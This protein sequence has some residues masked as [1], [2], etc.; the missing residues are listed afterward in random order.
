MKA[1][2]DRA[3][4]TIVDWSSAMVMG[5]PEAVKDPTV[6]GV[7]GKSTPSPVLGIVVGMATSKGI[8][9]VDAWSGDAP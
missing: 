6:I 9:P 5:P 7:V 1:L 2:L 3:A 4:T 8:D